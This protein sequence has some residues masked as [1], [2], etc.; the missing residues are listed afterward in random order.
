MQV[1]SRTLPTEARAGHGARRQAAET[2]RSGV[3]HLGSQRGAHARLVARTGRPPGPRTCQRFCAGYPKVAA[4]LS[5]AAEQFLPG[6]E[7]RGT[8]L[9]AHALSQ[10]VRC[11]RH[12]SDSSM[13]LDVSK[14]IDD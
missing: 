12:A 9:Q 7:C 11:S 5:L 4:N 3:E 1:P 2:L 8:L 13:L 10:L 6:S 14:F